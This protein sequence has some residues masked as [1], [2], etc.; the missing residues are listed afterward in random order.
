M[1]CMVHGCEKCLEFN[2]SETYLEGKFSAFEFDDDITHSQWDSTDRTELRNYNSSVEELIELLVY[3]VDSLTTHSYVAKSQARYLK[4][5]KTDID[6][7]V[8]DFTCFC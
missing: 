3:Q 2:N 6:Q 7:T 4:A 1:E 8:L 5:R